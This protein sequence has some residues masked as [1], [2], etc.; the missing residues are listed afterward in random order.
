MGY[1]EGLG[2]HEE[3]CDLI[4][5][6]SESIA[7]LVYVF[8]IATIKPATFRKKDWDSTTGDNDSDDRPNLHSRPIVGMV[9]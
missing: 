3:L 4:A 7:N 1:E 2:Y 5:A 9:L 6:D 8:H